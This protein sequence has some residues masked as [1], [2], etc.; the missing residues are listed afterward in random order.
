[1]HYTKH[2]TGKDGEPFF[3]PTARGLF[4]CVQA[5]KEPDADALVKINLH[6]QSILKAG[7]KEYR[8]AQAWWADL[9]KTRDRQKENLFTYAPDLSSTEEAAQEWI[10][11]CGTYEGLVYI[12]SV[13]ETLNLR[14]NK[15]Q[16]AKKTIPVIVF[17]ARSGFRTLDE[18]DEEECVT[19]RMYF[20][21]Y[22]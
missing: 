18:L 1:M 3:Q 2:G 6:A 4:L 8:R 14:T 21:Y 11:R 22:E 19:Y 10:N 12:F 13:A 20:A 15:T 7:S 16:G 9:P 5:R 17:N